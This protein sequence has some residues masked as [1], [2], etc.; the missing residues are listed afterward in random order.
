[1]SKVG[2]VQGFVIDYVVY[3]LR[4]KFP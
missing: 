4:V 1:M 2:G 3:S